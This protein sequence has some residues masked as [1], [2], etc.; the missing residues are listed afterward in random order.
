MSNKGYRAGMVKDSFWFTEF[1]KVIKLLHQGSSFHDIE[2]LNETEN[3]FSA[4]TVARSRQIFKT[5][6]TRAKAIDPGFYP[7]M[8]EVDLANQKIIALASIMAS[9]LLFFEFVYEVFREKLILGIDEIS[10]MDISIFFK[11]KQIQDDRAA[12]WTDNTL[13][14]LGICYKTLLVE[15][16]LLSR[17]VG[18]RKILRPILNPILEQKFKECGMEST[19]RA[20]TGVR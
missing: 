19:L 14:R 15:A 18:T 4:P 20:V 13:H 3:L 11:D 12:K 2:I 17:E 8:E 10:D 5:V 16:G 6:S 1:K 9:D 7:L